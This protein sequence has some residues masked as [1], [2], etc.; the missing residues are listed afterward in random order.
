MSVEPSPLKSPVR[1]VPPPKES[2]ETV[3]VWKPAPVEVA[4]CQLPP[5]MMPMS[6]FP[7]PFQSRSSGI[8]ALVPKPESQGPPGDSAQEV[9]QDTLQVP[10]EGANLMRSVLASPLISPA[11]CGAPS[12]IWL[13]FITSTWFLRLPLI[14]AGPQP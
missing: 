14:V 3:P 5:F 6:V 8:E 2:E 1:G 11:S 4:N 7:S 12:A 9:A 13:G 10:L